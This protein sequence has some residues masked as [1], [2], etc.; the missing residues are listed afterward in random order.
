MRKNI[1]VLK[2]VLK[3][4]SNKKSVR[5][6][7]GVILA[8]LIATTIS[9]ALALFVPKVLPVA[10]YAYWQLY[11]FYVSYIGILHMGI[12]DGIYL[13]YG[14]EDYKKLNQSLFAS[15]FW[16]L[17]FSQAILLVIT[18]IL[19]INYVDDENRALILMLLGINLVIVNARTFLQILLQSTNRIKDYSKNLIYERLVYAFLIVIVL[20]LGY[21]DFHYLLYAD[22]IAKFV[23][24]L[25]LCY[26]CKDIV[27][28]SFSLN[29]TTIYELFLNLSAGMKLM[30]ANLTGM[31]VVG[32]VRIIIE[33]RWGVVTFGQVALAITVA[34]LVL[35]FISA[36]GT[37]AYPIIKRA[38][39][40]KLILTYMNIRGMLIPLSL[41]FLVLY[42]PIKVF[43]FAWLP[44]YADAIIYMSILFPLAFYESK[45]QILTNTYL[46]AY[47]Q[48]KALLIINLSSLLMTTCFALYTAYI[49]G[50][51]EAT[52]FAIIVGL[53]LRSLFSELYLKRFIKRSFILNNLI[54]LGLVSIFIFCTSMDSVYG[55]V[56]YM[57]IFAMYCFAIRGNI[58]KSLTSLFR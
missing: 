39:Q 44:Q 45:T 33:N 57:V 26:V 46:K 24:L 11:I 29:R 37:V 41:G 13:R 35:V 20:V 47:R 32:I 8:N 27:I 2:N 42:F 38:S 30:I 1:V 15:Q 10:D 6:F 4:I 7:S 3:S 14:G 40:E 51:I 50:S 17:I 5:N 18:V 43:L 12:P 19:T 36:A 23:M 54:E 28:K 55:L 22:I 34:S 21:H 16:M 9:L 25:L 53:F 49:V 58:S 56:S 52:V 31:L 48:E